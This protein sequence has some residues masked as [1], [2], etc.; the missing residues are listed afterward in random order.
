MR[1]YLFLRRALPRPLAILV[2]GL[3]L[4]SLIAVSIYFS[5]EPQAEFRYQDV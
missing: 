2:T 4:L 5:F 3:L 1:T